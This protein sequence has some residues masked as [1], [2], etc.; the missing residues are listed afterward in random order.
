MT[1]QVVQLYGYELEAHTSLV[2]TW[3]RISS[4]TFQI[5]C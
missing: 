5:L 2:L 1:Y 3:A 4:E